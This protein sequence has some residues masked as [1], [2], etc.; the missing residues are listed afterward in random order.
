MIP[1]STFTVEHE[2]YTLKVESWDDGPS[3]VEWRTD[4][5]RV[6]GNRIPEKAKDELNRLAWDAWR[7]RGRHYDE[8][9]D[10][11]R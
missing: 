8:D 1:A 2:R 6:E 10:E 4:G 5:F 7:A 9:D 3:I 11:C